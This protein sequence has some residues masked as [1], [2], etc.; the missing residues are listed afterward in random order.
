MNSIQKGDEMTKELPMRTIYRRMAAV[1]AGVAFVV[2]GVQAASEGLP[3]GSYSTTITVQDIPSFFP[4]EAV[5]ILVGDWQLQFTESGDASAIKNG[6]IV[7]VGRYVSNPA[8]LVFQDQGGPLA[9]TDP[10]SATGVYSWSL[11]GNQVT[12]TAIHDA[13]AGRALVMTAHPWQKQT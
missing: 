9:C 3:P 7:V 1:L 12:A 4:P 8:R 2:V 13:C 5:D 11:A 6:E 10:G